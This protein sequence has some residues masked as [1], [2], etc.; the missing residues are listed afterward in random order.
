MLTC[1]HIRFSRSV[2]LIQFSLS[3][4]NLNLH[5]V[6]LTPI[7]YLP[8]N[9]HFP[10]VFF[11]FFIK[12][13]C[14]SVWQSVKAVQYQCQTRNHLLT[15]IKYSTYIGERSRAQVVVKIIIT[16]SPEHTHLPR[17]TTS[18]PHLPNWIQTTVDNLPLPSLL[19][20]NHCWLPPPP[21]ELF[22]YLC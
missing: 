22:T 12:L 19:T 14:N 6:S 7:L 16:K 3:Q 8:P 5:R 17:Q 21:F 20:T 10:R 13:T 9:P 11:F 18:P 15:C 2:F 1:Y 4:R